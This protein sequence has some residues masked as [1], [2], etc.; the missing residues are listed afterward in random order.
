MNDANRFDSA[1]PPPESGKYP[2]S[3][4]VLIA[5][6]DVGTRF[7]LRSKLEKA[8]YTVICA[9][10]GR[11]AI[12]RLSDDISAAVVDL[13]M[14]DI[15]GIEC[16]RHIRKKYPDI[17]P[18][19]LTAS[20]NIAN[21]VAAM[22]QGALDYVTKPFNA[23]QLLAL[24]EKAVDSFVQSRR[25]REAEQKLEHERQYQWFVASQIQQ[26]LLLGS[27]PKDMEGL[28]I[29][30]IAIPSLQ[31]DG[32]FI[33]FIRQGPRVM[34]L[35][36]A[37]VMGKGIMA[38]FMG[39]AL[40]SAFL[41]ALNDAMMNSEQK[42]P[43]EPEALV[44]AVHN[45]MISRMERLETFVTL[46]YGRF[47]MDKNRFVFVDCGHV[48]TL[49]HRHADQSINLLRGANMPL[50]FPESKNFLQFHADFLPG[51]LFLFYSDGLTESK[52]PAGELFGES[53]LVRYVE[54]HA[55]LP[56]EKLAD[57]IRHAA[58]E[59]METD[60]FQDDFTCIVVRIA[61]DTRKKPVRK[62]ETLE[63][64][65]DLQKTKEVRNFVRCFCETLPRSIR[66]DQT[67]GIEVAAVE[68]TTNII[69]H[70]YRLKTG[71]PIQITARAFDDHLELDFRDSG[72][73]FDPADIP[74]PVFD[75]SR[76]SGLGCFIIEQ[77][78]DG[79]SYFRD[80]THGKNCTRLKFLLSS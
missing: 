46:C 7:L 75:G 15:D 29:A 38:A 69:R 66:A 6:D 17:A 2:S 49:H 67:T 59:F 41:Q 23:N 62:K 43:P 50:G 70:A 31:I 32:D 53:R 35:V 42:T 1:L 45:H 56:P 34:D 30:R 54:K 10:N 40:K 52:N 51:D 74:A 58:A 63:I 39:A 8:G 72:I 13:K 77:T 4:Q 68:V 18:I 21:A 33:D 80:E 65:S 44:T 57:G 60:V 22:K 25:L 16:L 36:V 12:K 71:M 5:D 47:E 19:M 24:V 73:H 78:M 37:D 27:P 26:S 20:E 64:D 61:G 3:I 28:D 11:Q 76:E 48:Q 14:P 55:H 79:V 9:E